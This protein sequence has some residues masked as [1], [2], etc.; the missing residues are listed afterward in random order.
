MKSL[1]EYLIETVEYKRKYVAIVY[2]QET[3][4]KLRTYCYANGF[5]ITQDYDGNYQ[6]PEEFNF[7]TTIFYTTSKHNIENKE[8][9]LEIP[10]SVEPISFEM[11]G[12]NKDI[13]V[14]K[15]MSDDIAELR[16]YY[17][18]EYGMKDE[19]P[20]WKPHLSLSYSGMEMPD[21]IELPEFSLVYDKIVI[22]D[23]A[24]DD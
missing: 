12:H 6:N 16:K 15:V 14:I 4:D 23:G 20:D 1:K 21:N 9:T 8:V 22:D 24:S 3:Q 18:T 2:D 13:P 10:K 19:W 5:D 11:L 7:H 17:E